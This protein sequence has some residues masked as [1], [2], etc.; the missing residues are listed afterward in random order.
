M[1]ALGIE[2]LTYF[3][4]RIFQCHFSFDVLNTP[5]FLLLAANCN[6][7]KSKYIRLYHQIALAQST[8][9]FCKL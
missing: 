3:I 9:I 7:N 1:V 2:D 6:Q 8:E 5:N 4:K